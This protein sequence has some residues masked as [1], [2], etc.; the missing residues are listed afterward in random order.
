MVHTNEQSPIPRSFKGSYNK[1]LVSLVCNN[2]CSPAGEHQHSTCW[3]SATHPSCPPGHRAAYVTSLLGPSFS[4][5]C[6][7]FLL[8]I[9]SVSRGLSLWH[10]FQA[11]EDNYQPMTCAIPTS[12]DFGNSTMVPSALQRHPLPPGCGHQALHG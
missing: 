2:T 8:R 12:P 5:R 10:N 1:H 11:E 4:W 7:P 6:V 3:S 9:P